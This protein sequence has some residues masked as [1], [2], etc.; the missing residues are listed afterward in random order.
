VQVRLPDGRSR[1]VPIARED[2]AASVLFV[3]AQQVYV[4]AD[5]DVCC[6]NVEM[7]LFGQAIEVF[8]KDWNKPPGT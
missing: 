7:Q 4:A 1:L 8:S 3:R 2:D 6:E 5:I